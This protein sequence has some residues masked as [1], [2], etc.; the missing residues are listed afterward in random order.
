MQINKKS[1]A[2]IL[3]FT[4]VSAVAFVYLL[5]AIALAPYWQTLSG[6][7]IQAWWSG[8]FTRFS[9]LM[10]P[11]H[12][13]SILTTIYAYTVHRKDEKPFNQ[14]WL[15]ALIMLLICQ[16][17]NFTLHGSVYNPALQ[18][19][20]LEEAEALSTFDNWDFYHTIRTAAVCIS[21]LALI[22]IGAYN[23][24]F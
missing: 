10:V 15:L 1:A 23:K 18:S 8:P 17:F 16:V 2:Y 14:L 6:A 13:L 24:K 9:Y 7:D 12:L 21:L 20:I 22:I 5:I 11:V 19:G 3:A 4:F